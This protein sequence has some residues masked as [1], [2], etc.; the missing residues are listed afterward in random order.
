MFAPIS[1]S[2]RQCECLTYDSARV[3]FRQQHKTLTAAGVG[4]AERINGTPEDALSSLAG[5]NSPRA[6][7]YGGLRFDSDAEAQQ[8]WSGFGASV[9]VLPLWELQVCDGGRCFL[10]CHVRWAATAEVAVASSNSADKKAGAPP[11]PSW[12]R[13]T[14]A[15][16][17]VLQKLHV[18]AD[19]VSPPQQP[20][21]TLISHEGSLSPDDWEE[22]VQRVLHGIES[23][24]W[25]KVVLAQRV[26]L[27]FDAVLEPLHLL[28]RLLEANDAAIANGAG[29]NGHSPHAAGARHAYLFLLQLDAEA[30]F[31]GCT[32]E[33]LFKLDGTSLSTE[34]LAGTR[35]RGETAE[36]DTALAHELLHC[37]KDLREVT[38]VRD[39]LV[40]ALGP[41]SE[42]LQHSTP[43]VLQLRR[44]SLP[45]E[46]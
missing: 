12:D 3:S 20:L 8:E 37:E 43:F 5:A 19:I 39:F 34:A 23:G 28:Q 15:A 6:R 16:L 35:P 24:E 13:A 11:A 41:A 14:R 36:A 31:M 4:A 17:L 45:Q 33:K 2:L 10:A 38:A 26:R 29:Q 40:R 25:S 1:S 22:A 7:F 18:S 44:E 42:S 9:F 30:A 21:P 46:S 27:R 32:P